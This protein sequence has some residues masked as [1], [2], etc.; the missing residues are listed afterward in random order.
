VEDLYGDYGM[1]MVSTGLKG[2]SQAMTHPH[3]LSTHSHS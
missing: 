3:A 2:A 1:G